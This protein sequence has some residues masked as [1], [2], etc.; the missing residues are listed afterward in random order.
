[1]IYGPGQD[2]NEWTGCALCYT[3]IV[4]ITCLVI[5]YILIK[6]I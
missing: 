2:K 3:A 4:T 5:L 6:S 1:M